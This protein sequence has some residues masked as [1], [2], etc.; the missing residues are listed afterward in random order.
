M[1]MIYSLISSYYRVCGN[2][3]TGCAIHGSR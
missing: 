2:I 1:Y 3:T